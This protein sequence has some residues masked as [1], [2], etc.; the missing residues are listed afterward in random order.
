M[1]LTA[2]IE[3]ICY[4]QDNQRALDNFA[5]VFIFQIKVAPF[6]III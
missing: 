3:T 1:V 6:Q 2:L 4:I 5:A